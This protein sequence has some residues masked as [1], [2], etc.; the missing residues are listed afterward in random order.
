MAPWTRGSQWI[1]RSAQTLPPWLVKSLIVLF[2]FNLILIGV[3]LASTDPA[4]P[5][6]RIGSL[7]VMAICVVLYVAIW[8]R[9]RRA[10][11]PG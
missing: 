4:V 6:L 1:E 11:N 7:I 8:R 9:Q 10:R 3:T 5:A 2:N